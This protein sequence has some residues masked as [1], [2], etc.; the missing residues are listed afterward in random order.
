MKDL[1]FKQN[2]LFIT[3]TEGG[4][5]PWVIITKNYAADLKSLKPFLVCWNC[6]YKLKV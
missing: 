6:I 4:E 2:D 3:F 1:N 5:I